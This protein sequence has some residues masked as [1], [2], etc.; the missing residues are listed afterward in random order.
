[1]AA[2]LE[3]GGSPLR[4]V[5]QLFGSEKAKDRKLSQTKATLIATRLLKDI[6]FLV[7]SLPGFPPE[8]RDYP[9]LPHA[10]INFDIERLG[11]NLDITHSIIEGQRVLSF[12]IGDDRSKKEGTIGVKHGIIRSSSF[13]MD[14]FGRVHNG[15]VLETTPRAVEEIE[16]IFES[17]ILS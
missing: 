3:L 9:S 8:H 11:K 12:I 5:E 14:Y 4:R 13:N 2:V 16:R 1:M 15:P 10:K 17:L 7:T 6:D